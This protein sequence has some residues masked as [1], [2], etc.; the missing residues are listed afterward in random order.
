MSTHFT[1]GKLARAAGVPVSTVRY[2][3]QRGL[4]R[5]DARSPSSYRLY[6]PDG[7]QRLRFIRAA[8]ASGFTLGDIGM[9][10]AIRGGSR[11]PCAEVQ[12]ILERRLERVE[13]QLAELTRV[14]GVLSESIQWCRSPHEA[15]CCQVIEDLDSVSEASDEPVRESAEASLSA[16][17]IACALFH[18]LRG[19]LHDA[20][21]YV[22]AKRLLARGRAVAPLA[23]AKVLE[24]P[25]QD[26]L[27]GLERVPSIE[28]DPE[29]N[30]LGWGLT[31]EPTPHR[32]ELEGIELFAWC[33][34]DTLFFPALL[35]RTAT[36][37]STCPHTGEAIRLT[38]R[39]DGV[40]AWAPRTVAVSI[41]LPERAAAR[42]DVRG[43]F[44]DHV[45]YFRDD[46]AAQEWLAGRS[47]GILLPVEEAFRAGR[48]LCSLVLAEAGVA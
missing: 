34:F 14:H 8:Q 36:V 7:M 19:S 3:E 39:P 21:L 31:L 22:A 47:S 1:I 48:K 25:L 6:G 15:G 17:E 12:A 24:Q 16:D 32:I 26:V 9:L 20:R 40:E 45:H 27:D 44:C 33:A 35:G 42:N 18:G 10:L 5:P 37:H 13:R 30:L 4:L 46:D 11:D 2:Y 23:I 38:V 43:A 28:R 41:V 29:G